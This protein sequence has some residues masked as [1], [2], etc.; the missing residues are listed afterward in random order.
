MQRRSRSSERSSLGPM[1]IKN[2]D[3]NQRQSRLSRRSSISNRPM[4]GKRPSSAGGRPST[5][6]IHK[7]FADTQMSQKKRP[8]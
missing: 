1:R 6:G 5:S 8:R 2:D 3:D 4:A 7:G